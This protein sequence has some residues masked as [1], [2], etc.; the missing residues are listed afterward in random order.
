MN[1]SEIAS[2]FVAWYNEKHNFNLET[3]VSERL[4]LASVYTDD[5]L[6]TANTTELVGATDIMAYLLSEQLQQ[7]RKVANNVTVQPMAGGLL[8]IC[9]QGVMHMT[10]DEENE[11]PYADVFLIG[12]DPA[13][14][15][16]FIANHLQST[17]GA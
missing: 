14:G 6:F 5:T 16:F 4:E 8:L 11:I 15:Q 10:F 3:Q 17:T 13:S 12:Q 9:A 7:V 2:S 1:I